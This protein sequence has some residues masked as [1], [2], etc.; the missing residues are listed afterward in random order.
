LYF[1]IYNFAGFFYIFSTNIA[2]VGYLILII[3]IVASLL[4]ELKALNASTRS[5]ALQ[6]SYSYIFLIAWMTASSPARWPGHSWR[7][8]VAVLTSYFT[9][10]IMHLSMIHIRISSIPIGLHPLGF[11][12][13]GIR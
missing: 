3:F 11:F 6:S 12:A 4:M 8:P 7:F 5:A 2:R 1:A 10:T 9:T 13:K